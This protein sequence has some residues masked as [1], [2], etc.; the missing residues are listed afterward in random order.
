MH[1]LNILISRQVT[2]AVRRFRTDVEIVVVP[3]LCP[4]NASPIDF[5]G[6]GALIDRARRSTEAWLHSGVEMSD[7]VP[8][9]LP[10]HSHHTAGGT[11]GPLWL[12]SHA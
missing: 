9:Q 8:H 2:D 12:Q 11:Y 6:C 10:P 1:A 7:G 4:L 5:A 3:P